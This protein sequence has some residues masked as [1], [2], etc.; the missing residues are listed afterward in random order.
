MVLQRISVSAALFAACLGIVACTPPAAPT[1]AEP[2]PAA[3]EA[4]TRFVEG[5]GE[6]QAFN[7]LA[8]DD[9][10]IAALG[11]VK[12]D[13]LPDLSAISAVRMFGMGSGDP[14]MNG[15]K[16]YLAFVSPHDQ[17][18]FLLGDFRDYRVVAASP[19][20]IDLEYDED[21]MVGDEAQSRTQRAIV[22]W[23]ETP[24]ASSPNPEYPATVTLSPAQ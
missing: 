16:V 22:T 2:A 24:Q 19:G 13:D 10:A 7:P 3:V 8:S 6:P 17:R 1:K 12:F 4:P 23:T 21:F 5:E 15:L 9:P 11:V 20:R 14:A 18:A